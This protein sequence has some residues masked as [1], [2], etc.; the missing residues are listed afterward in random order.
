MSTNAQDYVFFKC[1]SN[2]KAVYAILF[3]RNGKLTLEKGRGITAE[4]GPDA[5][6]RFIRKNAFT[7]TGCVVAWHQDNAEELYAK[8]V[9]EQQQN[10][11]RKINGVLT[12]ECK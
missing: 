4:E 9:K 6:V 1:D 8:F 10:G 3:M 2:S 12:V 5:I 7:P 11:T